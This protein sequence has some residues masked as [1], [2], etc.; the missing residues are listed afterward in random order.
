MPWTDPRAVVRVRLFELLSSRRYRVRNLGQAPILCGGAY[1]GPG[2][3]RELAPGTSAGPG[4]LALRDPATGLERRFQGEVH[5]GRG[6]AGRLIARMPAREYVAGVIAGELG[7]RPGPRLELGAAVLRFLAQGPRYP[8]A[9]VCD[10]T[11]SARYIGRPAQ[12]AG[13]GLSDPDWDAICAASRAPG[14][15]QW[16][17]DDGGRPLAARDLW[18]GRPLAAPDPR[19]GDPGPPLPAGPASHPWTRTWSAAQLERAFGAPVQGLAVG[20]EDGAWVLRV[21][22]GG[23]KRTLRYDQA[24][25]LL[26]RVLGW[27]GLPSPADAVEPVAGGFMATGVGLGHR[28]GL[29]LSAGKA[30]RW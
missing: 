24:H 28:V 9:E 1:L 16:S 20:R 14:P 23:V 29:S 5:A 15:S 17:S 19:R 4:L 30:N 10:S 26:A 22:C 12:D 8:D 7:G 18:G 2:S 21:R 13:F 3:T 11:R 25:R 27:G 6:G